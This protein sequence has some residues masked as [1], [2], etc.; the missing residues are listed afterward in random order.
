MNE[1]LHELEAFIHTLADASGAAI[2]PYFRTRLEVED[3]RSHGQFDPVTQGD[4]AAE[5]AIRDLIGAT[6]PAHGILGEE[7][8]AKDGASQVS[9]IID[10]IDGTR[11]FMSGLPTWGTLIGAMHDGVPVVGVMDQPYTGERFVG[12]PSGA[13][14]ITRDGEQPMAVRSC[15]GL[16]D[17]VMAATDP[18]MFGRSP[19][20]EAFAALAADIKLLRY[21]G[22]CY[23]YA[24]VALGQ[25]DLVVEAYNQPYDILPLVPVIEAAGGIVSDWAG[26]PLRSGADFDR[27]GGMT[28]AAGD[29]R[30]HEAAVA[31]LS[32]AG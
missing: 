16:K 10:P 14:F 25:I 26:R 1:N 13:K 5:R 12:G 31:H 20:A 15:T 2:M 22:D 24:M 7:F 4:R 6:Y 23:N 9:W 29:R 11:A 27:S 8:G 18:R 21:G 28:L 32:L 19:Q 3:K 30:V 17:A